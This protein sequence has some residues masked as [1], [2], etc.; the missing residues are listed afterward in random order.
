MNCAFCG[1]R[2]ADNTNDA[3]CWSC[4]VGYTDGKLVD[5]AKVGNIWKSIPAGCLLIVDLEH[6]TEEIK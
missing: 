1:C 4:G 3:T 2:M 5:Y 6:C